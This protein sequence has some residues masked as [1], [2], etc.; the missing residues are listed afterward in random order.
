MSTKQFNINS[1]H[2]KISIENEILEIIPLGA[3][4]EVGRSCLFLKF[5]GMNILLDCG[6]HPAYNGHMSLPFFDFIDPSEIDI[7][8]ITHFHIDH[9]GALPYF[10]TKTNFKGK[11]FMTRPTKEI[12][13]YFLSDYIKISHVKSS[14]EKSNESLFN[15]NDLE[16]ST[17]LINEVEFRKTIDLCIRNTSVKFTAYTAGHVLGAAMFLIQIENVNILYTGDYSR[18]E[19]RHLQPAE[20][21][22]IRVDILISESTY[23]VNIHESRSDREKVF[24]EI[25]TD[26]V[27]KK[28]KC[29]LPVMISGRAQELMLILEEWW[30]REENK[31]LRDT[32]I[33]FISPLAAKILEVFKRNTNIMGKKIKNKFLTQGSKKPFDLEYIISVKNYDEMLKEGYD[34]S[35]PCVVFASPGMLQQGLSRELF[36]KWY[37]NENNATVI[38]GYCVE[39]TFAKELLKDT[40]EIT[41][42]NGT[43]VP[44]K[45]LVKEVTFSA[46]CDFNDTKRF[47][48]LIKPKKII[49]VHGE[50]KE[51][52]NLKDEIY[53]KIKLESSKAVK[54]AS[55]LACLTNT[56]IYTPLNCQKIHFKYKVPKVKPVY[57]VGNLFQ[58]LKEIAFTN[59]LILNEKSNLIEIQSNNI[60][61]ENNDIKMIRDSKD[62]NIGVEGE[63][64]EMTSKNIIVEDSKMN[65]SFNKNLSLELEEDNFIEF[66]GVILENKVMQIDD[67]E[68]NTSYKPYKLRNILEMSYSQNIDFLILKLKNIF[69]MN[70]KVIHSDLDQ[71]MGSRNNN[72]NNNCYNT[73]DNPSTLNKNIK[74]I[75]FNCFLEITIVNNGNYSF[76]LVFNWISSPVADFFTDSISQYIYQLNKNLQI[77]FSKNV[78]QQ[79]C[80]HLDESRRKK[81]VNYFN[82]KYRISLEENEI[83][84]YDDEKDEK[85]NSVLICRINIDSFELNRHI[86]YNKE[87]DVY[88]RVMEDLDFFNSYIH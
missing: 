51:M 8:L 31:D 66:N 3:G 1:G 36:E 46:H 34:E 26:V 25:V 63:D 39:N 28:G 7:L 57:I 84:I 54:E 15:E 58:K 49:L 5:S 27:R 67:I 68:N 17:K 37:N 86:D 21:P 16:I 64:M 38:T 50:S 82:S 52:K 44:L 75:A 61:K 47:I 83:L 13:K 48:E 19:D 35:K 22:N 80:N 9:C 14:D 74:I 73:S 11:C 10:L 78:S 6:I 77:N 71:D 42:S 23:G 81:F 76:S 85:G 72:E 4:S 60:Y 55:S 24:R 70:I 41:L 43:K 29:L 20:I 33:Y 40:N 56:K 45:M 62:E 53:N 30:A 32:K 88:K 65:N 59:N 87:N 2:Q 18:E 69:K 12:Y 79:C